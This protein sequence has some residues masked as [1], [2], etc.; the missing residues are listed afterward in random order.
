MVSFD[1]FDTLIT[2]TVW[3]P[4]GIFL[5]MQKR[6]EDR[7]YDGIIS[8][9]VRDNFALMR[10]N[11]EEQARQVSEH[12]GKEEVTLDEIY[13]AF[14]QSAYVSENVLEDLKKLEIQTEIE[15]SIAI[16]KNIESVK[17]YLNHGEQVVLI[18]DMY[19][20]NNVIR[21][22]L[23]QADPVL[24]DLPLYVSCECGRTKK[25][26]S[27]YAYVKNELNIAYSEWTHYGD[28]NRS[29]IKIP[30]ILGIKAIPVKLAEEL[31]RKKIS[32]DMTLYGDL[33]KQVFL[34]MARNTVENNSLQK[35]GML[36]AT[37]GG[38]LLYPYIFWVV[39]SSMERDYHR[40]YFVGRDGF[41]LKKIADEIIS[42]YHYNLKTKYLYGSRKAWRVEDEA[43]QALLHDYLLQEIVPLDE[44]FALVDLQGTGKSMGYVV[45]QIKRSADITLN[46]FYYLMFQS[47]PIDG[48]NFIPFCSL[49][50]C[51]FLEP[52]ARAPHGATL[53]Y[54]EKHGR[55]VP[56]LAETDEALWKESGLMDYIKGIGLFAREL[57]VVL[58]KTGLSGSSQNL[59][60]W[61]VRYLK[62]S[63]GKEVLNFI[64]DMPH[65]DTADDKS[66]SFAPR[67]S[68]TDIYKLYL[69]RTT[70][71]TE[72]LYQG[73]SLFFSLK[74]MSEK[75]E[76]RK[77]FFE[78]HAYDFMGKGFHKL[79]YMTKRKKRIPDYRKIVIYAAGQE[80]KRLFHYI[81][82]ETRSKVVGW[83]DMDYQELQ[84]KGIPV[85]SLE[86]ALA[87]EYDGLVIAIENRFVC[88]RVRELLVSRGVNR[89]KIMGIN[90][91]KIFGRDTNL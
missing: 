52:F 62:N 48:C 17:D 8:D 38:F 42:V 65:N 83:T 1:I 87:C 28:N 81:T 11:A 68:K 91:F 2:R 3:E 73:N 6:L 5:L 7:S 78:R 80:G 27:L 86:K 46:V 64:G 49:R 14:A 33:K 34:G 72:E 40:L 37:I 23:C 36:G 35:A 61:A 13:A 25:S 10:K 56:C 31:D 12:I 57:T 41:I 89:Q 90:E 84:K 71:N 79:K 20:P 45:R 4:F 70:E 51:R 16:L 30:E 26:G 32:E 88:E 60:M 53:G 21:G 43:S 69:W 66:A 29:D 55:M 74:R 85:V 54:E 9:Y 82:Y 59:V 22:L 47:I 63:A 67:L 58:K 24:G 76:R 15:N 77:Q 50:E 18:S 75:D 39:C 44:K 19:L